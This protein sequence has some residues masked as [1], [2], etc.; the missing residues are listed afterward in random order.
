MNTWPDAGHDAVPQREELQLGGR[1]P[2]AVVS[3]GG[4]ATIEAGVVLNDIVSHA[5]WFVTLLA[6]AGNTEIAEQLKAGTDLN[7]TEYKV[8]LDG[9]NQLDYITG[10]SEASARQHFF[11]VSD[12]GDLTGL[13]FHN[14]KFVFMEQ[15]AAGTLQV[16]MEPYTELRIPKIF[17]LRTDPYER[18]DQTSNTYYD[19]IMDHAFMLVPAQ[20][21][22]A[23]MIQTLA[24][25]PP[26]QAPAS[27]SIDQ[28][29]AKLQTG[30]GSD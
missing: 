12:D 23:E 5:D 27:F 13:R 28:V 18:A 10:E 30:I 26:R 24:E 21:Y 3:P 29:M 22:V 8:H 7:G 15:R 19:W 14:W 4:P 9:H 16:W 2:R 20:M 17:N 25:F 6:A 1:V 11:Y